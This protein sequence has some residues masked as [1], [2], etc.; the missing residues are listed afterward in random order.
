LVAYE[1]SSNGSKKTT[2][3]PNTK[4]ME[5][6]PMK[7]LDDPKI[8]RPDEIL[9]DHTTFTSFSTLPPRWGSSRGDLIARGIVTTT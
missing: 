6:L 4:K 5:E 9:E 8:P 1:K 3:V 2:S 7:L